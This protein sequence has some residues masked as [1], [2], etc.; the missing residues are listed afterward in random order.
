MMEEREDQGGERTVRENNDGETET[1]TLE[2]VTGRWNKDENEDTL[3]NI[4]LNMKSGQLIA[5]IG[6]VGMLTPTC[7]MTRYPLWMLMWGNIS[8]NT[9]FKDS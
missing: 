6:P 7:W 5:I 1:V 2:K 8:F 4:N 9:A 3:T